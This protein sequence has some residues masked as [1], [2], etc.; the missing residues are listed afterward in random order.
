MNLANRKLDIIIALVFIIM[1]SWISLSEFPNI[2][3]F[4]I[5]MII[6]GIIIIITSVTF[7]IKNPHDEREGNVKLEANSLA[8]IGTIILFFLYLSLVEF[9]ILKLSLQSAWILFFLCLMLMPIMYL[10][11]N[12]Y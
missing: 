7:G 1:G 6:A 2:S 3:F 12:K 4:P 10:I 9:D 11:K 8:Y 5:I